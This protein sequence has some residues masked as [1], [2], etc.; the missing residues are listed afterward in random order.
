VVGIQIAGIYKP[1]SASFEHVRINNPG[2]VGI[3]VEDAGGSAT[4][5]AVTVR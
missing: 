5:C 3:A 2:T 1:G 4:F